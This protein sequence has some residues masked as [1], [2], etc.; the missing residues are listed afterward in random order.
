MAVD[1]VG[2]A[3][4]ADLVGKC[5]FHRVKRVAGELDR[6]GG[7]NRNAHLGRVHAAVQVASESPAPVLRSPITTKGGS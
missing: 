5:D 4:L 3:E 6:L 2:L 1:A 7:A